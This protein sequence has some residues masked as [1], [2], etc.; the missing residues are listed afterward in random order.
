MPRSS[1]VE[2]VALAINSFSTPAG[3]VR[4]PVIDAGRGVAPADYDG[5]DVSGALV[6]ASGPLVSRVA[7]TSLAWIHE[8]LSTQE[9]LEVN[10]V[11]APSPH[12]SDMGVGCHPGHGLSETPPQDRSLPGLDRK[13]G[14]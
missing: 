6:L 11:G 9:I 3:G 10:L 1:S 8:A 5:K 13:P 4:L 2:R 7:S 12:R 14:A